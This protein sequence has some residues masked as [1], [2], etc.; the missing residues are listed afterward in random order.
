MKAI[1]ATIEAQGQTLKI[2]GE[3]DFDSVVSICTRGIELMTAMRKIKV[4]FSGLK[5][6][7]SSILALCS[8]WMRNARLQKKEIEFMHLP[9]FM[10]D[11]VRVHGLEA[12]FTS[13]H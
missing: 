7:D 13:S 6:C 9:T 5:K 10:R 4:E 11:L 8:A 2:N 12:I 1:K 3:L